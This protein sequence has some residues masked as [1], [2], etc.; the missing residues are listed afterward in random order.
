MYIH[1]NIYLYINIS[2]SLGCFFLVI[3]IYIEF[4]FWSSNVKM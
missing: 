4:F 1:I 2:D 3:N